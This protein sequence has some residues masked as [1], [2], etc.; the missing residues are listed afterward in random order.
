MPCS[1]HKQTFPS[2]LPCLVALLVVEWTV[3]GKSPVAECGA[4]MDGVQGFESA[5]GAVL[6][7]HHHLHPPLE[8]VQCQAYQALACS[9]VVQNDKTVPVVVV[10]PVCL[11][12][13]V[14]KLKN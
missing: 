8:I 5:K 6:E 1:D 4:E 9:W 12:N 14:E 3:A 2:L 10:V 13:P 11:N 7:I